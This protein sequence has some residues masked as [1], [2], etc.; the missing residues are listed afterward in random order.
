MHITGFSFPTK[1][2]ENKTHTKEEKEL[3]VETNRSMAL[4]CFTLSPN[5]SPRAQQ[6]SIDSTHLFRC[7]VP[8]FSHRLLF[9]RHALLL[10][11]SSPSQ[12]RTRVNFGLY[13]LP[14]INLDH[15]LHL[16]NPDDVMV[17]LS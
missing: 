11:N 9:H 8:L 6:E 14:D 12:I 13:C 10:H 5:S 15:I 7:L 1:K 17:F 16:L 3:L 4:I 2:Q